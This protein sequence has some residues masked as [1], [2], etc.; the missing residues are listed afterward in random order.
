MHLA[1]RTALLAS[2]TL[3]RRRL[4]SPS[5]SPSVPFSPAKMYSVT[6]MPPLSAVS[7]RQR[8]YVI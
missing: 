5:F 1:W 4:T 7:E 6:F 2:W 3:I 8:K